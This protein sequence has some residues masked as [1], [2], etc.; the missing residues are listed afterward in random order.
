MIRILPATTI[1]IFLMACA[2]NVKAQAAPQ[3]KVYGLRIYT[4]NAVRIADL[5]DLIGPKE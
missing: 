1:P 4:A 5:Q 2:T 3:S